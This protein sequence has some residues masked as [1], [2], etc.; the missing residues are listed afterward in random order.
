MPHPCFR[1]Q[2]SGKWLLIAETWT[3]P[4]IA[5]FGLKRW[6]WGCSYITGS[7]QDGSFLN[8]SGVIRLRNLAGQRK[9]FCYLFNNGHIAL[10]FK[11]NILFTSSVLCWSGEVINLPADCSGLL[12][13]PLNNLGK[14]MVEQSGQSHIKKMCLFRLILHHSSYTVG[15][16]PRPIW[17]GLEHSNKKGVG[18]IFR[19]ILAIPARGYRTHQTP[20]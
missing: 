16:N 9:Y 7:A 14:L 19:V 15:S 18:S 1:T 13:E 12:I 10:D 2:S 17:D 3:L 6:D 8:R 20:V 4:R 11:K 5:G